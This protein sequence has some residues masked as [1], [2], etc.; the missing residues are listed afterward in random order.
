MIDREEII[1]RIDES[2][3]IKE[4]V[5]DYAEDILCAINTIV[6]VFKRGGK[7]VLFGN[8]GSASDAQH[9]AAEFMGKFN[10]DRSPL[11]AIALTTNTS[12][13]TAIANDYGYENVFCRQVRA[14]VNKGD[15][16]IGISTS[17]NSLNVLKAIDEANSI[18][19]ITIAITGCTGKLK[20]ISNISIE[21]SSNKTSIVQESHIMIGHIICQ[22]VESEIFGK[23]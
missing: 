18:G 5:I 23:E 21:I 2:S 15:I 11:P 1:C 8:G 3:N 17:G 22:F 10:I 16:V 14:L 19:A 7:V 20:D 6:S 4:F 13:I 12:L 9:I